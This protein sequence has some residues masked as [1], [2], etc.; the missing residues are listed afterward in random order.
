[1]PGLPRPVAVICDLDGTL[2]D[3]V[4]IRIRAWLQTF[5]EFEIPVDP[6]HLASL[7]GSDGRW[8]TA[9]VAAGNGRELTWAETEEIDH[10]A[11]EVYGELNTTPRPPPGVGEF[12]D[13]LE[14]R[15]V[16]WAIATSSRP[17]QTR[18]SIAALGLDV[19]PVVVDGGTVDRAKPE[20]DLLLAAAS[21]LAV[22]PAACW[23]VGDSTWDVLAA[24]AAGMTPVAVTTGSATAAALSDAGAARVVER[25]DELVADLGGSDDRR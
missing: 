3:T 8:L 24:R 25:L 2:V 4:P 12:L 11:G 17:A 23:C 18:A 6:A 7:I 19:L 14:V 22:D 10:R 16:P 1:M 15:R 21:A 13:A 5:A 20:P 9:Q